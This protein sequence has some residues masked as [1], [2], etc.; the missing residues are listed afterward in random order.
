MN[1]SYLNGYMIG[2]LQK[3]AE[4]PTPVPTT[5]KKKDLA[6]FDKGVAK[7]NKGVAAPIKG[8]PAKPAANPQDVKIA[9]ATVNTKAMLSKILKNS[10]GK[11]NPAIS[12]PAPLPPQ[13]A[14]ALK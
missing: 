3:E 6:A 11:V 5:Q 13:K 7:V 8:G 2:Y 10:V 12:R 1:N 14:V 4:G 9:N